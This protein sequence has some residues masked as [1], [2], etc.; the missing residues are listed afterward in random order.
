MTGGE[1]TMYT[2]DFCSEQLRSNE[3]NVRSYCYAGLKVTVNFWYRL[4]NDCYEQVYAA[5][6]QVRAKVRKKK[7]RE[8]WAH[9]QQQLQSA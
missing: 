3:L 5:V 1:K 7:L 8:I 2:C 4:C 6:R 9:Y